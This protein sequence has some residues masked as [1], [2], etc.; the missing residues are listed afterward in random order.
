[1]YP[2][3]NLVE[4]PIRNI[5]LPSSSRVTALFDLTSHLWAKWL[6]NAS[7][8]Q[9]AFKIKVYLAGTP[10]RTFSLEF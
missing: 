5:S 4:V 2:V 3:E 1:M 9:E 10:D 8:K 6:Q 7:G